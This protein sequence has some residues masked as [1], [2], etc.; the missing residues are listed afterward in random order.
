MVPPQVRW[1]IYL[2]SFSNVGTGYFWVAT[3]A[4]LPE[5]GLATGDVGVILAL[6]GIA[7]I[8]AAIPLGILADHRGRKNILILGLLGMPP[9]LLI[10]AMTSD[11]HWL[12]LASAITGVSE[13]AFLTTW[14]ALIADM[15]TT[16]NR[17]EAFALSFIGSTV[18]SGVGL[19]LPLAFPL[20]QAGAGLTSEDVHTAFFV[21]L[22]AVSLITPLSIF[23][24]LRQYKETVVKGVS[25][26][27]GKNLRPMLKFS[28]LNS[29][30]GLGAGIIIPLIP[31]WMFLRFGVADSLSGPLLAVSSM[32]VGFV[33]IGSARLGR[34]FGTVR[35]IVMT[36]GTSCL[37]MFALAFAPEAYFAAVLYVMRTALMNMAAPL[38]DSFLMGIITKEERGLAS[39]INSL[40]W[41]LPHSVTTVI[42][43][44][45]LAAG[46][47][48]IPFFLAS[49]FYIVSI[50]L[51]YL[52]FRNHQVREEAPAPVEGPAPH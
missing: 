15:T 29:L 42:G 11:L 3:S 9:A 38:L 45:L 32:T 27:R 39:A 4:Y 35:A 10:Y 52:T 41:R 16:E 28:A 19:A 40:V 34:R 2:L 18:S 49:A 5:K 44:A 47:Y 17:S 8:I 7:F 33:S 31:T 30:I 50:S 36:Q 48:D 6:N 46:H 1:L 12:M 13:G 51:F 43:G 14:N 22:A 20:L 23:R 37:F 21:I 26:Q 25:L 24:L